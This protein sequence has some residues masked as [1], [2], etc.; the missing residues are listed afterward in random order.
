MIITHARGR[1]EREIFSF[2]L[3]N[4]VG[5]INIFSCLERV[6]WRAGSIVCIHTGLPRL[7]LSD[8]GSH[9]W[10]F[11]FRSKE[12]IDPAIRIEPAITRS[13]RHAIT[14]STESRWCRP[15]RPRTD[16][17]CSEYGRSMVH[18]SS[19]LWTWQDKKCHN[20]FP[21]F[22]LETGQNGSFQFRILRF[23]VTGTQ[24]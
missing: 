4:D 14:L 6:V 2:S 20:S 12:I 13:S 9:I 18:F 7:F 17:L 23:S 24:M 1:D 19:D 11:S 16:L 15:Q 3:P 10:G 5:Q 8:A 21:L 22:L